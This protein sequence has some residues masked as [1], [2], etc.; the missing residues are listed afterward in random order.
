MG[1]LLD[2]SAD[3][4][5]DDV[6]LEGRCLGYEMLHALSSADRRDDSFVGPRCG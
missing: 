3:S 1:D 5:L 4:P 6:G 2:M